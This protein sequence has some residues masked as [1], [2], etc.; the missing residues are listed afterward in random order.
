MPQAGF[1]PA[2]GRLLR[3][4]PLPLGYCGPHALSRIRTCINVALDHAPLPVGLPE[5]QWTPE[6]FEPSSPGCKPGVLPIGRRAH[7]VCRGKGSNLQPRPSEGRAL[8][9][10]SYR[11]VLSFSGPSRIRTCTCLVLGQ[12]PLP[13]GLLDRPCACSHSNAPS[14]TR[15]CNPP[16]KSRRL[17]HLSYR[18]QM[19]REGLEP[20]ADSLEESC[21]GSI[22]LPVRLFSAA[23]F[24][25]R[26]HRITSMH[27]AGF[28]PAT[29][30]LRAGGSAVELR[31]RHALGRTRTFIRRLRRP[32]LIHLSCQCDAPGKFRACNLS[33]IERLLYL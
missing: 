33:P 14:R 19:H 21:S 24:S 32:V 25:S 13:V 27:P 23:P 6:G 16:V 26:V 12:V 11:N 4:L 5:R 2:R 30:R 3:P 20:S 10:L 31:V 29:T 18:C 17:C 1:E 8:V 15:T 7:V 22:E 28:E 9:R